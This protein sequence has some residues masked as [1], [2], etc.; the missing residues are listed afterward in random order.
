MEDGAEVEDRLG[1]VG[2][3]IHCFWMNP[4]SILPSTILPRKGGNFIDFFGGGVGKIRG[5]IRI[6][7][8]LLSFLVIPPPILPQ[9][10]PQS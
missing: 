4:T 9:I 6:G 3:G 2:Q 1:G 7:V 10:L 5:R 8:I